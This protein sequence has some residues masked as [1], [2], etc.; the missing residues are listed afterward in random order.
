MLIEFSPGVVSIFLI[1]I[2][3][4]RWISA[5]AGREINVNRITLLLIS[6]VYLSPL[7]SSFD[8][9]PARQNGEIKLYQSARL[10]SSPPF[11]PATLANLPFDN[12][13]GVSR[14]YAICCYLQSERTDSPNVELIPIVEK[15][16]IDFVVLN[17]FIEYF[18]F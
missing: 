8:Q 12:A 6:L 9:G 15:I 1:F 11:R 14:G 13:I 10:P 5:C 18:I 17:S 16:F 3:Q 4:R 7:F 2:L